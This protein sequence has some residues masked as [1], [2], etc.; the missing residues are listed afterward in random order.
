VDRIVEKN[1]CYYF[2]HHLGAVEI[3][4]GLFLLVLGGLTPLPPP[5]AEYVAFRS[6]SRFL[7]SKSHT[8]P[9]QTMNTNTTKR[10]KGKDFSP[11][12]GGGGEEVV[13]GVGEGVGAIFFYLFF[14]SLHTDG[15]L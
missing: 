7:H 5:T 14:L 15:R 6:A 9:N 3:A 12:D 4:G 10:A 8:D 1:I 13:V 11:A 2:P